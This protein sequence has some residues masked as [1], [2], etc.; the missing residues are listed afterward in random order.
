ME[1]FVSLVAVKYYCERG[2]QMIPDIEETAHIFS[3][4]H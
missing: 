4:L 3:H 1:N 2:I